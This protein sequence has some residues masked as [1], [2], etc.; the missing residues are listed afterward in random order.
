MK[1]RPQVGDLVCYNAAGMKPKTLGLVLEIKMAK[2]RYGHVDEIILIQ[3]CVV[4][5]LMPRRHDFY[6][7]DPTTR[8]PLSDVCSGCLNWYKFGNWF[9]T[10]K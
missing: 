6:Y 8:Y 3:W 4:G 9:E 1:R 2:P 7:H 5:K 10:V